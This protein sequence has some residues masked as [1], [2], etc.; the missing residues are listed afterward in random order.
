MYALPDAGSDF[1]K[2][3]RQTPR[4]Y[5]SLKLDVDQN[6]EV[7]SKFGINTIP[8]LLVFKNGEMIHQ[9]VGVQDEDV[10]MQAVN[11]KP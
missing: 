8:T 6:M 4:F 5:Q 10:L 2:N 1:R 11:E 7:A 3:V 9:F